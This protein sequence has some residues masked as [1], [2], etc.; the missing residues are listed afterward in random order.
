MVFEHGNQQSLGNREFYF[1][2]CCGLFDCVAGGMEVAFRSKRLDPTRLRLRSGPSVDIS[3]RH[4]S[5]PWSLWLA[6]YR[7]C[8]GYA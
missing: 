1:S 8:G 2:C 4:S 6:N 3:F 7:Q 5:P